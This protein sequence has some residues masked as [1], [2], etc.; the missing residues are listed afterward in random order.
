MTIIEIEKY[1]RERPDGWWDHLVNELPELKHLSET[2]QSPV[3][4]QEGDVAIHT[5]MAVEACP[6]KCD[7]DLLWAALLHDIG[8]P[9][10][11]ERGLD[12]KITAYKHDHVGA[13]IA[14][15]ILI[16]LGASD[17][18][19]DTVVWLVKNHI[20]YHS[21]QLKNENQISRKQLSMIKDPRFPLLLK[22]IKID[23]IASKSERKVDFYGFY[24][25]LWVENT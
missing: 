22:L 7:P 15:E 18:Q 14:K 1:L 24:H 8:K 11:T 25:K 6:L 4:H 10:T 2:A 9:L 23:S 5:R 19:I 20:F 17:R 3:H 13:R 21:W 12:G 16:R